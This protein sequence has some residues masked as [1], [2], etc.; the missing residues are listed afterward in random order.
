M[1]K[2][3]VRLG[4]LGAFTRLQ[5][6]FSTESLKQALDGKLQASQLLSNL[7]QL[8]LLNLSVV[9]FLEIKGG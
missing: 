3:W 9:A 7:G 2:R 1:G 4:G 5:S 6:L 8:H